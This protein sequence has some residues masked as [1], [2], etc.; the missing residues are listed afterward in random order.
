MTDQ[1]C[2]D[3]LTAHLNSQRSQYIDPLE[4]QVCANPPPC[5]PGQ[6]LQEAYGRQYCESKSTFLEEDTVRGVLSQLQSGISSSTVPTFVLDSSYFQPVSDDEINLELV[7]QQFEALNVNSFIQT[8]QEFKEQRDEAFNQL[9]ALG[10][11]R[12]IDIDTL[13][14][15][16]FDMQ[17]AANALQA[18]EFEIEM[19]NDMAQMFEIAEQGLQNETLDMLGDPTSNFAEGQVLDNAAQNFAEVKKAFVSQKQ[20]LEEVRDDVKKILVKGGFNKNGGIVMGTLEVLWRTFKA[21]FIDPAWDI[22]KKVGHLGR[23]AWGCFLN[24]CYLGSMAL[25]YPGVLPWVLEHLWAAGEYMAL[26][27][28]GF[29]KTILGSLWESITNWVSDGVSNLLELI[30]KWFEGIMKSLLGEYFGSVMGGI[31]DAIRTATSFS[32]FGPRVPEVPPQVNIPVP[33]ISQDV[34]GVRVPLNTRFN[35]LQSQYEAARI[36]A[37][38]ETPVEQ[39]SV[40]ETKEEAPATDRMGRAAAAARRHIREQQEAK[41]AA[42]RAQQAE[43]KQTAEERA[44]FIRNE[45]LRFANQAADDVIENTVYEL[46]ELGYNA[47]ASTGEV[48]IETIQS[49]L[50]STQLAIQNTLLMAPGLLAVGAV[51]V[52]GRAMFSHLQ[53]PGQQA[54]P[55]LGTDTQYH[56]G[57]TVNTQNVDAIVQGFEALDRMLSM[58]SSSMFLQ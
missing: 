23:F 39:E 1:D 22:W 42:E 47:V 33:P 55:G 8:Q 57:G 51:T 21:F 4:V 38:T 44:E 43:A 16:E 13:D 3:I 6:N 36:R 29:L 46:A 17:D 26:L 19:V 32:M 48:A 31:G 14:V 2:I 30:Q 52:G 41:E 11:K 35:R 20:I 7:R 24:L 28:L 9:Q 54:L 56:L 40:P 45:A 37:S 53:A 50:E 18:V 49:A 58:T 12:G 34:G 25:F 5:K 15:S 10:W 27:G